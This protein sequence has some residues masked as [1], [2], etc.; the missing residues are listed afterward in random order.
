M[1]DVYPNFP[2]LTKHYPLRHKFCGLKAVHKFMKD[3][4]N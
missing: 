4:T 3:F 1:E 2:P